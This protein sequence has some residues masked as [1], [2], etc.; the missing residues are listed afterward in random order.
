MCAHKNIRIFYG[1]YDLIN[2]ISDV[3]LAS[4]Q[5]YVSSWVFD[6]LFI[7]PS[8]CRCN[9]GFLSIVID[10]LQNIVA[11]ISKFCMMLANYIKMKTFDDKKVF[12]VKH[13]LPPA[14]SG[15]FWIFGV[16]VHVRGLELIQ[17]N[18]TRILRGTM[19]C[20]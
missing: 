12:D 15:F 18:V 2:W 20:F 4:M 10:M 1:S 17:E 3:V 5:H 13:K 6:S 7:F 11:F 19:K 8:H 14:N 16:I 9:C